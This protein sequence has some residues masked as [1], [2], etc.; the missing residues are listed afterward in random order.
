M[1]SQ[2]MEF[3]EKLAKLGQQ[4]TEIYQEAPNV[5]EANRR[6]GEIFEKK[7]IETDAETME[8]LDSMTPEERNAVIEALG[9]ILCSSESNAGLGGAGISDSDTRDVKSTQTPTVPPLV[10]ASPAT[11]VAVVAYGVT[12]AVSDT[13]VNAV[14]AN[15]VTVQGAGESRLVNFNTMRK[16]LVF[17]S[18]VD[19]SQFNKVMD[20]NNISVPRR[21]ALV[22]YAVTSPNDIVQTNRQGNVVS[23]VA[24]Y[25]YKNMVLEITAD[26]SA[27]TITITNIT[28]AE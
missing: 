27:D 23:V 6:I 28:I 11:L 17:K 10:V 24:H 15:V 16:N 9:K 3:W 18:G 25:P 21:K 13:L 22:K 7:G 26:I 14:V 1:S 20:T 5:T 2:S 12:V 19:F 8:A 4:L